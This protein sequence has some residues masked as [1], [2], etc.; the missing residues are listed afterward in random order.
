MDDPS[1]AVA[2]GKR[3]R[4]KVERIFLWE[5]VARKMTDTYTRVVA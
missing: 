1:Q 4:K 5:P 2:L 3:G